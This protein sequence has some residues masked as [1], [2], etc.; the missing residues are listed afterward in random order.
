MALAIT[1]SNSF[2]IKFSLNLLCRNFESRR[3]CTKALFTNFFFNFCLVLDRYFWCVICNFDGACQQVWP[4]CF[5]CPGK[6]IKL[7][8]YQSVT[9]HLF[10]Y[11]RHRWGGYHNTM[12]SEPFFCQPQ[13]FTISLLADKKYHHFRPVLDA[14]IEELFGATKADQ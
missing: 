6:W 9:K 8:F 1:L 2:Q 14:Y 7:L 5:W 12:V 4:A 13:V 11:S 3:W 10:S